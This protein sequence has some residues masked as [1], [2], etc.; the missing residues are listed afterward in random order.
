MNVQRAQSSIEQQWDDSILPELIEYVRIPNKSPEF[1]PDWASHGYMDDA[2]AMMER[3]CREQNIS[4]ASIE[5]V[6]LPSRTPVLTID[7]PAFGADANPGGTVL[8]Y[9]HLGKQPEMSGWREDLGPWLPKVEDGRLYG[10]GGADDGYAVYASL[11]AIMALREQN[12]PHARCFVLIEACE[13]SG[14]Y[15]L[16]FYMQALSDRIGEPDLVI[17]L[18][19][20]CGNYEQL[21]CTTSL[22]GMAAGVLQVRVL[23]VGVHS[24]NA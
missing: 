13:E 8:L 16:P 15:D 4:G 23:D 5:V 17:C 7:I 14:S 1:D 11:A 3:W 19:S 10:R 18:D 22:R 2:V 6:R 24:G 21:W 9:G 12:V 20:G